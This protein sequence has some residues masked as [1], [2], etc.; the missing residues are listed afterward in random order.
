M[1]VVPGLASAA[2]DMSDCGSRLERLARESSSARSAAGDLESAIDSYRSC[3]RRESDPAE[4][5][6]KAR[7][8]QS[9]KAEFETAMQNLDSVV[10]SVN[11]SCESGIGARAAARQNSRFEQ[12]C[13]IFRKQK[14]TWAL[15]RLIK[16][17][18]NTMSEADCRRC[19]E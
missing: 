10:S 13:P 5:E 7:E 12:W 1:L 2:P 14:E 6:R 18:S 9:S 15:D 16:A 4:C 19:L 11:A 17:C 3:R 8:V